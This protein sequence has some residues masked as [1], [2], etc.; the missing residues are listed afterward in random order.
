M[1]AC[2]QEDLENVSMDTV[3]STDSRVRVVNGYLE[4]KDQTTLD[5]LKAQLADKSRE[6]LDAW[7]NQFK[8]FTSLRSLDE[9]S[10]YAQQAWFEELSKMPD[11]ERIRLMQSDENFWYS[12]FIKQHKSSFILQDSGVYTLKL[13]PL[14]MTCLVF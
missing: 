4:F 14:G 13:Q 3:Q 10:I 7:E 1:Y 8:G 9:Q 6:E 12:D 5:S 11:A 2:S